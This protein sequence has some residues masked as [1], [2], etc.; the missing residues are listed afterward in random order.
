MRRC[1]RLLA[2]ACCC[3]AAAS[4]AASDAEVRQWLD[5]MT[6]SAFVLQELAAGRCSGL[7]RPEPV[8]VEAWY[9]WGAALASPAGRAATEAAKASV[10]AQARARATDWIAAEFDRLPPERP[11]Q[12]TCVTYAGLFRTILYAAESELENIEHQLRG[13]VTPRGQR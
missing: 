4:H 7:V 9:S 1:R 3:L 5:E 11:L 13:R 8:A 6:G 10:L 12:R 2:G